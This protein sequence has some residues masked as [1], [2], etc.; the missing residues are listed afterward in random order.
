MN[1]SA[2]FRGNFVPLSQCSS[3]CDLRIQPYLAASTGSWR[4]RHRRRSSLKL[5][6]VS[7]NLRK[8]EVVCRLSETQTEPDSNN[9]EE[10]EVNENEGG[11]SEEPHLDSQP[12]VVDQINNDAETKAEFGVQ[13]VDN[14][15]EVSSGSP[16]PGVKPQQGESIRIPKETLDILK[17]QV[18]GFDTFFVTAQDP[19]EAGV[20]FKGN[21]RGVAAKSYEKISKRMQDKFG[22]E[23]KLFL[24]VNPEDDQPVA[25]VVPRRTLQPEST[26]VPEWFAAGAFGLVTLFTLLLRNVPELQSNLLSAYDN[27]ELLKNGLPGA[28]ERT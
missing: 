15:V 13:D 24:L 12:I 2:T 11:D 22:D 19:Y 16:L 10:K 27:L 20:L 28:I 8:R 3:C 18:F 17:N 25:V 7:R 9:D 5:Y 4:K 23:Y 1:L 21:L 14:N 6:Q 26:A